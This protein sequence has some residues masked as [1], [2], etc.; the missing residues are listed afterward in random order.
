[1]LVSSLHCVSGLALNYDVH[2]H[3]AEQQNKILNKTSNKWVDTV[4]KYWKKIGKIEL[5]SSK[6]LGLTGTESWVSWFVFW[7]VITPWHDLQILALR[8]SSHGTGYLRSEH[9]LQNTCN[10]IMKKLLINVKNS[11]LHRSD[12]CAC[13]WEYWTELSTRSTSEH[14]PASA[15]EAASSQSHCPGVAE[16]LDQLSEMTSWCRETWWRGTTAPATPPSPAWWW[17][18]AP[19]SCCRPWRRRCWRWPG[20][21]PPAPGDCPRQTLLGDWTEDQR[22]LTCEENTAAAGHSTKQ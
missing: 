8:P 17:C 16:Y 3:N 22:S 18:T 13:V 7:L 4:Q 14:C 20:C 11:R 2:Q 6:P 5:T 10:M 19:R 21:P 1:M 15:C 12:S 9:L